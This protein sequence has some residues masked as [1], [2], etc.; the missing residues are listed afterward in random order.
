M[1]ESQLYSLTNV[2]TP[3][4]HIP[5]TIQNILSPWKGPPCL[6]SPQRQSLFCCCFSKL[7]FSSSRTSIKGITQH[8]LLCLAF[9]DLSKVVGYITSSLYE[10]ITI[11][12]FHS[13]IEAH[14]GCFHSQAIVTKTTVNILIYTS[15]FANM[16]FSSLQEWN[17]QVKG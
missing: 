6:P 5:H 16:C 13:P 1:R 9:W 17:F 15:L 2:C 10:H 12:L 14:V 11:C 3:V 7:S 4:I 8:V